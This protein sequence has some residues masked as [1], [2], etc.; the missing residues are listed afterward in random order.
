MLRASRYAGSEE[1]ARPQGS[2]IGSVLTGSSRFFPR[3]RSRRVPLPINRA[4]LLSTPPQLGDNA[5]CAS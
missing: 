2:R 5:T 3:H 1:R 4:C